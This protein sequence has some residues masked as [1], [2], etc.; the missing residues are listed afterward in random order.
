MKGKNP[1]VEVYLVSKGRNS[2]GKRTYTKIGVG[3]NMFD[4]GTVNLHLQPGTVLDWKITDDYYIT[5]KPTNINTNTN[6]NNTTNREQ[7]PF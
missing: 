7:E 6:T 2:A 4:D 1:N 3:W 5:I